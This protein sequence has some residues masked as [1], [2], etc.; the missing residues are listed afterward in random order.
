MA[1]ELVLLNG[2]WTLRTAVEAADAGTG[3]SA[4]NQI[5][6]NYDYVAPTV[7]SSIEILDFVQLS[8]SGSYT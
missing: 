1:T 5:Y 6:G 4:T 7:G 8:A 3:I 2:V